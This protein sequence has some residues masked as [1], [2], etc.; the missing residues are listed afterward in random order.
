MSNRNAAL[1]DYENPPVIEVVCGAQFEPLK[2]FTSTAFGTFWQTVRKEYPRAED[3]P[4]LSPVIEKPDVTQ[5]QPFSASLTPPLRRVFLIGAQPNWLVQIQEDRFLHNWRKLSDEDV[6]PHYPEVSKRFWS[7]WSRFCRFCL[8]EEIER[9]RVKQLEMTY[10]NHIAEGEGWENLSEIGA[11][12][13]DVSWR[14]ARAFLPSPESLQWASTFILPDAQGRMHVAIR[15]A[16][17]VKDNAPVLLCEL[18]VRGAPA[19]NDDK[20]MATWFDLAREWI[21]R[22]FADLASHKIQTEVWRRR[23]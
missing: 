16:L 10:V 18:T 3:Q 7:A 4:P 22:A 5:T 14:H 17:R 2:G 12:F 21:V 1:P 11:V 23:A 20:A 6:Y 8:S 19:S 9:P 13:P 15:R